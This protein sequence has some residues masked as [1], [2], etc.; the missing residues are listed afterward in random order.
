[1]LHKVKGIGLKWESTT[2]NYLKYSSI[3]LGFTRLAYNKLH[4]NNPMF[5]NL[6][7]V[8]EPLMLL[9]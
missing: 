2:T 4:A 3:K 5:F 6:F 1:V 9:K 7:G 8:A